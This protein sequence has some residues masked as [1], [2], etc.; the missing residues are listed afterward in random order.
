MSSPAKS[1]NTPMP[2]R[3]TAAR[4]SS[5]AGSPPAIRAQ[6]ALIWRASGD[7]GDADRRRTRWLRLRPSALALLRLRRAALVPACRA[8][9]GTQ[10]KFRARESFAPPGREAAESG[11]GSGITTKNWP[12]RPLVLDRPPVRSRSGRETGERCPPGKVKMGFQ[13]VPADGFHLFQ[14]CL[15]I[16]RIENHQWPAGCGDRRRAW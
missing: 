12:P 3:S 11:S 15:E 2:P 10:R 5:I 8:S 9:T 16:A 1:S 4:W 7:K 14:R 6:R 13:I